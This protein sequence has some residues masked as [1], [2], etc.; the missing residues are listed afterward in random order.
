MKCMKRYI[1]IYIYIP[2]RV[3][4]EETTYIK[5]PEGN[6]CVEIGFLEIDTQE[7]CETGFLKILEGE[8]IEA[9]P[10]HWVGAA[11][12]LPS[13]CSMGI[14]GAGTWLRHWNTNVDGVNSGHYSKICRY[15]TYIYIYIYIYIYYLEM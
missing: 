4:P 1:Y 5:Q 2:S 7:E 11:G 9:N 6:S 3:E 13:G 10:L 14:D 15:Y 8:T 12:H